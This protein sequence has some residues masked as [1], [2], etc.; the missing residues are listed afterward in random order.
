MALRP[1]ALLAITGLVVALAYLGLCGLLF[2]RQRSL[3]YF[4][5]PRSSDAAGQLLALPMADGPP[6]SEVLVSVRRRPGPK[7]LLYF[8]GNAEA[9]AG[10]LPLLEAAFPEHSL[11]LM[12]YRGYG[13]S[14]GQPSELALF[15]DALALFDR[16]RADHDH[17]AV[18]GRSLGSGVAVHLAARRP[19]A[20]LVLVTPFDSI[21]AVA[22]RQFPLVPVAVLL[23]DKYRSWADA[24]RVN[25]PT[26]LIAAKRDEVIPRAH[27]DALLSHFRPGVASL[28]VLPVDGHNAVEG[29]PGYVPL[30][31]EFSASRSAL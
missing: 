21:E 1:G 26:L 15:A 5:Q 3:L 22:S 2:L 30:L 29:S 11:Y 9:V 23:R 8:G 19:V 13:G 25:A 16:V 18:L 28:V 20:R 10:Q 31:R 7:A 12:H 17:I 6:G 24:P 4:P 27:T 14:S